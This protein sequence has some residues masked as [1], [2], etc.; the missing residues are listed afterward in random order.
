MSRFVYICKNVLVNKINA[1]LFY[2]NFFFTSNIHKKKKLEN[3]T[4]RKI[5]VNFRQF[6]LS[7]IW[8]RV[9]YKFIKGSKL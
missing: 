6:S 1:L 3:D 5:I 2:L 9:D 4:C 8:E 7:S